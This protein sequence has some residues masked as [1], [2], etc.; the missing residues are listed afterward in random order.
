MKGYEAMADALVAEGVEVIFGVLGGENDN[1]VH[2][3]VEVGVR[4]VPV[5][6]EQGAVGMADGYS[7]ATGRPGVATVTLGGALTN[8][9]TPMTAARLSGSQV[10]VLVGDKRPGDGT[11][12]PVRKPDD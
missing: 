10:L 6:H 8:A 1:L 3:L 5:R 4:Y 7:R 9:A 2:R 12:R 11:R